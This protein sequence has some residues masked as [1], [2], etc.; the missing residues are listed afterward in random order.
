MLSPLPFR[1]KAGV[2]RKEAKEEI[3]KKKKKRADK[4]NSTASMLYKNEHEK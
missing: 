4:C 3:I 1:K 2:E